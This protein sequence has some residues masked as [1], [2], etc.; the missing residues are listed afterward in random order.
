MRRAAAGCKWLVV[1]GW[2]LVV[3]QRQCSGA[4]CAALPLANKLQSPITNH[5]SPGGAAAAV[6][7]P[8]I[9]FLWTD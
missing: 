9:W 4:A 8:Y 7:H 5:Q 2:W 3:G 1:G 6:N